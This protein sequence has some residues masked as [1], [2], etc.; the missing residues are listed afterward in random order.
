MQYSQVAF[1][2]A[3]ASHMHSE[4]CRQRLSPLLC[5][6]TQRRGRCA[7]AGAVTARAD[8]GLRASV[9]RIWSVSPVAARPLSTRAVCGL[10]N[11]IPPACNMT[12][13]KRL[14]TGGAR[15]RSGVLSQSGMLR[16]GVSFSFRH[17]GSRSSGCTLSTCSIRRCSVA[18][19]AAC[20]CVCGSARAI[21]ARAFSLERGRGSGGGCGVFFVTSRRRRVSTTEGPK[22]F[23]VPSEARATQ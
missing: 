9:L 8:T 21:L 3:S 4:G 17:S 14:I 22:S 5:A 15:P 2:S 16:L 20:V 6:H 13:V 10:D 11:L 7:P 12:G 18:S 23:D 19:F 1:T